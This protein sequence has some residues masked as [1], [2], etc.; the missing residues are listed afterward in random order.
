ML[1]SKLVLFLLFTEFLRNSAKLPESISRLYLIVAW[2]WQAWWSFLQAARVH[3][4][5]PLAFCGQ[6]MAAAEGC[7]PSSAL[8]FVGLLSSFSQVDCAAIKTGTALYPAEWFSVLHP[9]ELLASVA[10][11]GFTPLQSSLSPV[12][13]TEPQKLADLHPLQLM[14]PLGRYPT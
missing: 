13:Y 11:L 8:S 7:S 14:K 4:P 10:E 5:S 6:S 12:S 2:M 1:V 9:W 3:L